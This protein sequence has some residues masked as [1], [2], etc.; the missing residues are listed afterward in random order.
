M[1]I[2]RELINFF[3]LN[4]EIVTFTD[5]C[6]WFLMVLLAV[7]MVTLVIKAMFKASYKLER[8]LR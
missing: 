2:I 3:E 8:G 6:Q 5:F 7:I 4:M 1:E